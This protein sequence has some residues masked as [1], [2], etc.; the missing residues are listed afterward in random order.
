M[1]PK[2]S[3]FTLIELMVVVALIAIIATIAVPGFRSLIESN[4]FTS[5][6]NNVLG[7]LNYARS[8]AVRRGE[9][10]ALRAMNGDLQNGLE[11]LLERQLGEV[12]PQILRAADPMPGSV[13]LTMIN[14]EI[15]VFRGN[16][17]KRDFDPT[18]F[19]VCPGNGKP[20]VDIVINRG[21]QANRSQTEPACS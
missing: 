9:P 6:T 7:L 12:D 3:G 10:V 5:T 1:K 21:G 15:P 14:G 18:E 2:H 17:E 16:G 13:T 19:R 11:V 8:E 4:R 20:G